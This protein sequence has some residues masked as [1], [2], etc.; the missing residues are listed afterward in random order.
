TPQGK[1]VFSAYAPAE[2]HTDAGGAP[3]YITITHRFDGPGNYWVQS[4]YNGMTARAALA[5][6][7]PSDPSISQI[8]MVVS[9]MVR[10]PTPV[11]ADHRG[12]EP[13]CT[14]TPEC[15]WHSVSL[16]AALD[17][18]R[19]LAVLFATPKLCQ[20][21]VCGPVLD[22][23]LSVK[24]QFESKVRFLHV[25]VYADGSGANPNPPLSPAI[26][27]Y[28]LEGEPFLFLAGADGKVVQLIDG[29]FGTS[30]VAAALTH[31]VAGR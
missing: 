27:A 14:R 13:I 25:E 3:A 24:D 11:P 12:V 21:A 29:L 10:V 22:T 1:E 26:K 6:R 28:H 7:A 30:E 18:H 20:T 16:D 9:A 17:E 5:I 19:P 4:R 2:V 23:M 8:P 15:P 31:L